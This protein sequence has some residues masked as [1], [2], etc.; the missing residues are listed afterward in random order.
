MSS[1]PSLPTSLPALIV[2]VDVFFTS[3]TLIGL[4]AGYALERW[5]KKPIWVVPFTNEQ[6]AHQR[7][8]EVRGNFTF[9]T[10]CIVTLTAV[11]YA[12]VARLG[13]ASFARGAA[14]FAALFFGFQIFYY[15]LHRAMHTHALVRFHR[16]HHE[17]R[18][19]TP[20]SGQ[21]TSL[22]EALGWMIG[23]A[24]LPVAMSFIAPISV[25]GWLAYLAFNVLGNIVGHANVEVIA[26][27]RILWWRSTTA[28]V[29]TYHALH[30]ARWTGHY[31]FE[32]TW[33]DRLF[34]TEWRDWPTLHKRIWAGA[35]LASLKERGLHERAH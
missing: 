34:R 1:L 35:P 13:D 10:V 7:A 25:Y 14:T 24:A 32:S 18:V 5:W 22:V 20:L 19:T 16:H 8:L 3:L 23:Y 21:S 2:F 30:H 4:A 9:I 12:D 28:A 6:R 26:P 29:F 17:S 33:A 31:G 11:L 27:S 15:A